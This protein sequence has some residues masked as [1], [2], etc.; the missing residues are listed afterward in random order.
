[1]NVHIRLTGAAVLLAV[2]WLFVVAMTVDDVPS[3][4]LSL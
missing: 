4:A 2:G 3:A 1:V